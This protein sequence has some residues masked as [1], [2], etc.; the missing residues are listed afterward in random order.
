MPDT[1]DV[2]LFSLT[3]LQEA[4]APAID[5]AKGIPA[6]HFTLVDLHRLWRTLTPIFVSLCLREQK[7]E[8]RTRLYDNG[9]DC[10]RPRHISLSYFVDYFAS[11]DKKEDILARPTREKPT[12]TGAKWT[13][14]S[15]QIHRI[16][17][18][19]QKR[20]DEGVGLWGR[21]IWA[22]GNG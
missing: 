1:G 12:Y 18:E 4:Y 10:A 14:S 22:W 13:K 6:S 7:Q 19:R 5:I 2:P 16:V 8:D 3:K 11:A 20:M 15:A 21:E 9:L 17:G